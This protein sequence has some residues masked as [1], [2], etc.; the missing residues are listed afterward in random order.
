MS[1]Q[2]LGRFALWASL[3][4]EGVSRF[5][6]RERFFCVGEN[7]NGKIDGEPKGN[8]GM[9]ATVEGID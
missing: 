3:L 1:E 4:E 2:S 9:V 8:G 6:G 5:G 7:S